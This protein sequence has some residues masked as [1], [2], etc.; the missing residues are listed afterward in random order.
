MKIKKNYVQLFE[1]INNY[2]YINR[3]L[4]TNSIE[5]GNKSKEITR[6]RPKKKV[7]SNNIKS[8]EDMQCK[9][10]SSISEWTS[11]SESGK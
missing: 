10:S 5:I 7:T 3:N 11:D 2:Y 8:S 4:N 1:S 6:T 9:A